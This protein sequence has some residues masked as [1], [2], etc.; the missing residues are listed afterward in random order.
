MDTLTASEV[1][2]FLYPVECV[3]RCMLQLKE[4]ADRFPKGASRHGRSVSRS[5]GHPDMRN[6]SHLMATADMVQQPD[7]EG[8]PLLPHKYNV[9]MATKNVHD[10]DANDVISPHS[11][12][13]PPF[14]ESYNS[15]DPGSGS[16][17]CDA[18]E[19]DFGGV[20]R[21]GT[22]SHASS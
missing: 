13:S 15:M 3:F 4:W 11:V 10:V 20:W 8:A 19:S 21:Q 18:T 2:R 7:G 5:A 22:S 9:S 12:S 16:S 17:P 1:E 6:D 14:P